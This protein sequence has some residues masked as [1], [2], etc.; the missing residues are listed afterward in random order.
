MKKKT[1]ELLWTVLIPLLMLFG[2]LLICSIPAYPAT[3]ECTAYKYKAE[4]QVVNN[5]V[6]YSY[7]EDGKN[8]DWHI[9]L[10]NS[11]SMVNDWLLITDNKTNYSMLYPAT[12][13]EL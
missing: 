11:P 5:F 8:F 2:T 1:R 12:C 4:I 3:F 7:T 10:I 13:H 6:N 9:E